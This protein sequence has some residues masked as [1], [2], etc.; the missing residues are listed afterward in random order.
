MQKANQ[1]DRQV[2][3]MDLRKYASRNMGFLYVLP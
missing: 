1:A 2:R 3:R